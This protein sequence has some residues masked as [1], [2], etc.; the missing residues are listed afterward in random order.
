MKLNNPGRNYRN[1]SSE[2][3]TFSFVPAGNETC[4]LF[5]A[6][7]VHEQ[8]FFSKRKYSYSGAVG[9]TEEACEAPNTWI[10]MDGLWRAVQI[11]N[12]Q[13]ATELERKVH[14]PEAN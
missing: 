4:H 5:A 1:C 10:H 7:R 6:E 12:Q 13:P 2:L 8:F 9:R 14:V 3:Y 11:F